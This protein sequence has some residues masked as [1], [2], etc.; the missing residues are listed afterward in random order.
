MMF[1]CQFFPPPLRTLTCP[2]S[3]LPRL[4]LSLALPLSML[5]IP[6]FL[7]TIREQLQF[8][9]ESA[10]RVQSPPFPKWPCNC[11]AQTPEW[12]LRLSFLKR[13]P[14]RT[15]I[16]ERASLSSPSLTLRLNVYLSRNRVDSAFTRSSPPREVAAALP[17]V[18]QCAGLTYPEK[19]QSGRDGGSAG[20]H[21][22]VSGPVGRE[23]GGGGAGPSSGL[24]KYVPAA[25]S[26][27][28]G[29]VIRSWAALNLNWLL[30]C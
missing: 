30:S 13:E 23:G 19:E 21:P 22:G 5:P 14:A 11:V 12:P 24:R 3:V 26:N 4:S 16:Y 15:Q 6:L 1:P 25:P 18:S 10:T 28:V 9:R 29:R 2:L 17:P 20:S 7:H 8:I 27:L